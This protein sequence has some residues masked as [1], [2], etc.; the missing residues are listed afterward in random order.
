M[1]FPHSLTLKTHLF[2]LLTAHHTTT[3]QQ[4][5]TNAVKSS[6]TLS[7]AATS[8]AK[9]SPSASASS[10]TASTP[11]K[12]AATHIVAVGQAEHKFK[13]DVTVADVGDVRPLLSFFSLPVPFPSLLLLLL[14]LLLPVYSLLPS[15]NIPSPSNQGP[16]RR[17]EQARLDC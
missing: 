12:A 7:T 1:K 14:L 15:A 13:P 2:F 10:T 3:A 16:S 5:D 11:P 4:P 9:P 17:H 8:S 6:S